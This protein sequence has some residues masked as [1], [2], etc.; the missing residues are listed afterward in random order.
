MINLSERIKQVKPSATLAI[1]AMAKKM[2]KEGK[3]V[4]R[5]QDEMKNVSR[6]IKNL[7]AALSDV[8]KKIQSFIE[9]LPNIPADDVPAGEKENNEVIREWGRRPEFDFEP[10]DHVELV[11]RLDL[12]DYVV[13]RRVD[14]AAV[15]VEL[16]R[17]SRGV[18]GAAG[19]GQR[20]EQERRKKFLH[21]F[22]RIRL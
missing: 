19:S 8:E 15:P 6:R 20:G 9:D 3:D 11:T 14:K 21:P 22:L 12:I 7:D 10:K 2:K 16:V 1:T 17:N 5:V 13:V 4:R 18:V